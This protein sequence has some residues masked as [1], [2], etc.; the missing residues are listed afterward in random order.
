[1]I[2]KRKDI[3]EYVGPAALF[4]P[5]YIPPKILFR[6]KE[7]NSLLSILNDSFSDQYS[8]NILYQ[9]IEGIGKKTIVNKVLKDLFQKKNNTNNYFKINIDCKDKTPEELIFSLITTLI[10]DLDTNVCIDNLINSEISRLWSIFKLI[11]KK[12]DKSILLIFNNSEYLEPK[13]QMKFLTFGKE[14]N[15][16][17]ISTFNKV[18]RS[19]ALDLISNYDIKRRLN[20]FTYK[21]LLAIF[22]QRALL[23]FPHQIDKE[24]IYFMTDL[25]LDNYVPVPGP[26]INILRDLYPT[27]QKNDS[28][29]YNRMLEICENHFDS[30][31]NVDEF[32]L[33]NYIEEENILTKLFLDN[34][35]NYFINKNYTYY[36]SLKDLRELYF[37][38]CE[39]LEY[40]K[41]LEEFVELISKFI[42]LGILCPSK[43][44]DSKA[45]NII[46]E[47]E[48]LN[49]LYFM[50]INPKKLKIVLDAAFGKLN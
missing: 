21:Q 46:L 37:I 16:T 30:I 22:Q 24:L 14:S 7:Q 31:K 1:M 2:L 41:K 44:H 38:S 3:Q 40:D 42:G 45:Q 33:L 8:I 36:I 34:L 39:S 26:G 17:I 25:I 12:I 23:T 10:L 6:T 19:S 15:V 5:L 48:F 18:L 27:L 49:N 28:I 4:D 47:T 29:Q 43:K 13:A 9:G 20:Y 32:N 35:S 50:T 11:C